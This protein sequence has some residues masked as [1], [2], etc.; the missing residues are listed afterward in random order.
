MDDAIAKFRDVLG[1]AIS[2]TSHSLKLREDGDGL[3]AELEV[4]PEGKSWPEIV[5]L[6]RPCNQAEE[7]KLRRHFYLPHAA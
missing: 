5:N 6:F 7:D 1:L 4:H 2:E 3:R